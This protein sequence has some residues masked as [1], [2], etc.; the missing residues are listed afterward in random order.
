MI[1]TKAFFGTDETKHGFFWADS[2]QKLQ[3]ALSARR[4]AP[5]QFNSVYQCDPRSN[6]GSVFFRS[7][8]M[9]FPVPSAW[10]AFIENGEMVVQSWDTAGS[11]EST[12]DYTVCT[13]ALLKSCDEY[14]CNED[15]ALLGECEPHFDVYVMD[16][17]RER[18]DFGTLVSKAREMATHWRPSSI[19]I[20]QK[21]TGDP[22][23]SA[24]RQAGLP[25]EGM[26]PGVLSKRARVTMSVGAGSAQGWFRQHRVRFAEGAEW[27]PALER[28]LLDFSGDDSGHD[29][30]VDA[31]T[32][33]IIWAIEQAGCMGMLPTESENYERAA[34]NVNYKMP[35]EAL[36]DPTRSF[37]PFQTSCDRCSS[38]EKGKQF[39]LHH[40]R[41]TFALNTCAD[42]CP[43]SDLLFV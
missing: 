27:L 32:Y 34:S 26:K 5:A 40:N 16:V 15:S 8:F 10:K 24:L 14:H 11:T 13:T 42:M 9:Y 30:Q 43:K 33:L 12:A 4:N 25:V 23:L 22:L 37:D 39:C 31:L 29:D 28:E 21:S 6:G 19:L 3:E 20:E 2:K 41:K 36:L 1:R 17:Y 18:I 7:D 35:W 38:Y